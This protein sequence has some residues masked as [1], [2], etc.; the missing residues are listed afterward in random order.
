MLSM[1]HM[2]HRTNMERIKAQH[3]LCGK[4]AWVCLLYILLISLGNVHFTKFYQII[5]SLFLF[6]IQ[7]SSLSIN[8]F[9]DGNPAIGNGIFANS[10]DSRMCLGTAH[11]LLTGCTRTFLAHSGGVQ[12]FQ[13]FI[14][15]G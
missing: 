4:P 8:K 15:L 12:S 11:I 7:N 10:V 2:H 9:H 5:S 14:L 13:L 6:N 1:L 3:L